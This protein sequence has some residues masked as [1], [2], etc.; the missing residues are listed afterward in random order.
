MDTSNDFFDSE[1][2]EHLMGVDS[3][4][5]PMQQIEE[6]QQVMQTLAGKLSRRIEKINRHSA[7]CGF[8]L[9]KMI[10]SGQLIPLEQQWAMGPMMGQGR[11]PKL[12][13]QLN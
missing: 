1:Q 9:S 3:I 10:Q 5:E 7:Q 4:M 13:R 2:I 11:L 8:C 12:H 6:L